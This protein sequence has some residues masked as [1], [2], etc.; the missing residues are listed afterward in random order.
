[1]REL[2][3]PLAAA[4][5]AVLL[6]ACA[7][8]PE[9]LSLEEKHKRMRANWTPGGTAFV[10]AESL[11]MFPCHDE[12]LPCGKMAPPPVEKVSFQAP[13]AGDAKK[14][15]AIATNIRYGNCIACHSLP[16]GHQGGTIGPS[17]ADYAKRAVPH[18]VTYQRIWDTR[19]FNPNAFMPLYGP[20]AVLTEQEIRD[21]M[22]FLETG[23]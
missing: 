16:N 11:T 17:L 23:K 21:V 15:E 3:T 8:A 6:A 5:A 12:E 13:L 7:A 14:G 19:A 9:R 22:A 20:N 2:R 18:P 1:M 4:V 10:R